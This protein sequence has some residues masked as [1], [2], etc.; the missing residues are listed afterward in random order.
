MCDGSL[1]S[2]QNADMLK[3][4]FHSPMVAGAVQMGKIADNMAGFE[5]YMSQNV[6]SHTCGTAAGATTLL[7]DGA[8]SEGDET[9]TIDENGSWTKTF[10]EG[11]I[12]SV[13]GVNAV[14]PISGDSTGY[15]R[16]FVATAAATTAGNETALPVMPGGDP[17]KLYS[18][19][20]TENYLPYQNVS[21]LPAD[22]AAVTCQGSSGL[23]HKVN[24]A[25]HRH[26]LGLCMVPL[27]VP[28]SVSWSARESY[29]GYSIRV[30]RDY[31][32][33]NDQEYVRFDVLFGLKV[34]NP[35]MACRVAG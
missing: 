33:V 12:I 27:E 34:L 11:D 3:G 29:K 14:N 20:A 15:L 32:V 2:G 18:P 25:F 8:A 28:A 13:A 21:A 26:A 1:G 17:Y 10:T 16:Q 5:A 35:L 24:M 31:D 22:N 19:S 4:L 23:V 6:N 30:I 7:V 9:I